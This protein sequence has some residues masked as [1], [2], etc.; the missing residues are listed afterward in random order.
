[1]CFFVFIKSFVSGQA[2]AEASQQN[3]S[4]FKLDLSNNNIG[5]PEGDKA[6]CLVRMG[7][8]GKGSEERQSKGQ[9]I[10]A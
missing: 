6:W 10:A 2:L 7:L 8:W 9:G 5:G 4:L 1:M 3:S